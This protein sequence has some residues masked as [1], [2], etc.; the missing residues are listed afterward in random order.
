MTKTTKRTPKFNNTQ[1]MLRWSVNQEL[2]DEPSAPAVEQVGDSTNS[3]IPETF[4]R[5][6]ADRPRWLDKQNG[7]HKTGLRASAHKLLRRAAHALEADAGDVS[8]LLAEIQQAIAAAPAPSQRGQPRVGHMPGVQS[9][10]SRMTSRETGEVHE[11][12]K[13]AGI[14]WPYQRSPNWVAKR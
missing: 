3:E 14:T 1:D 2:E 9:R 8:E 12:A 10:I 11:Q 4:G 6:W 13:A 5:T 7:K